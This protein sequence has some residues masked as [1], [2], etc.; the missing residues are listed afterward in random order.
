MATTI[1]PSSIQQP[2]L[3]FIGSDGRPVTFQI[4]GFSIDGNVAK[5]VTWP[6]VPAKALVFSRTAGGYQRF[7]LDSGTASGPYFGNLSEAT[8]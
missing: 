5:A 1:I 8:K 7:D 6:A 4:I 3:S 2:D